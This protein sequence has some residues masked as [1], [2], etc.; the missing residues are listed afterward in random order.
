MYEDCGCEMCI[1]E[2]KDIESTECMGCKRNSVDKY[3]R[4]T[5]ADEIR[6]MS[7]YQLS[8]FLESILDD[9]NKDFIPIG[10]SRCVFRGSKNTREDCINCKFN[11]GVIGWLKQEVE[12]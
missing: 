9:D 5:N 8:E 6:N 10:C 3:K 4:V 12:E 1:N 11:D 7:D 2:F